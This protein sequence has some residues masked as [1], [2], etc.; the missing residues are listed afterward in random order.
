MGF[1]DKVSKFADKASVG[2]AKVSEFAASTSKQN[3]KNAERELDSMERNLSRSGKS[4]AEILQ[5]KARIDRARENIEERRTK[6]QKLQENSSNIKARIAEKEANSRYDGCEN[7]SPQSTSRKWICIGHL[8]NANL[9]P[10]NKCVGI[11]RHEINGEVMYVGRA[12]E[13]HNGGFRKRLSDYRRAS[14]SAR[15]HTSG[16]QINENLDDII[17]YIMVVGDT[18][19]AISETK[20]LEAKY[21]AKYNPPW[22]KM[23]N[24]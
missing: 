2:V 3:C 4:R 11:Y 7:F 10:Y 14:D 17:T 12:I 22:N 9:T 23:K 19:E 15:K 1:W 20:L 18:E 13:L 24:L 6:A 5:E 8:A 16:H 21:V